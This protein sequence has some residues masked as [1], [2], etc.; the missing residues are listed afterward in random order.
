[1]GACWRPA[2]AIASTSARQ[3]AGAISAVRLFIQ[4]WYATSRFSPDGRRLLV[5][6]GGPEKSIGG[7]QVWEVAS[8]AAGPVFDLV[9]DDD[10][11][12]GSF[13]PDWWLIVTL[14]FDR[15]ARVWDAATVLPLV[16]RSH[17]FRVI[18]FW[19]GADSHQVVSVS[20]Q[21]AETGRSPVHR[22]R[23]LETPGS[24]SPR[25]VSLDAPAS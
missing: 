18:E 17:E 25:R 3:Q 5:S 7:A 4:T 9:H 15:T 12:H 24:G 20:G 1:M 8:P 16:V 10:V 6:Y 19:I 11:L 14:S 22:R 23:L 21:E 13:S 2:P